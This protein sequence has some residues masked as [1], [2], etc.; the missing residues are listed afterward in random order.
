MSTFKE[1]IEDFLAQRSIAV[2]GLSRTDANAANLIYNKLKQNG[3]T[4]Y[5]VNP[6]ATTIEGEPCYASVKALPQRPDGVVIVTRP[7]VT[8]QVV[9]DCVAA[10]VKRIWIHESL[11]HGGT[12]L[13]PEAVEYCEQHNVELIA[14]G[15]PMMYAEPV[16]FGHKCMKWMMRVS[17]QLPVS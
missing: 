15:C 6:N 9:E 1:K 5:A 4:V 16:D 3:H 17:G 2:V 8:R 14:G 12:S 10:G 11:I 7:N 13:A